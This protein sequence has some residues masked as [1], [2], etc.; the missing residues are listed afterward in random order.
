MSIKIKLGHR[1]DGKGI[2]EGKN[3]GKKSD[4]ICGMEKK[5]RDRFNL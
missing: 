4:N 2:T 5:E 3:Q 1:R